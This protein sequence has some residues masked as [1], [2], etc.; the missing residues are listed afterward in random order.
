M[1]VYR[2]LLCTIGTVFLLIHQLNGKLFDLL[3]IHVV[4]F[5]QQQK[6]LFQKKTENYRLK[7]LI[8]FF[9]IE[10]TF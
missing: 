6:K 1:K 10:I 7:K 4:D 3:Y 2:K 5:Y 8:D 9:L